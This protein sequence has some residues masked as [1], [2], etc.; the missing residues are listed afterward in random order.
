MNL[1]GNRAIT[2]D[3]K[4]HAFDSGA[5]GLLMSA[6]PS[7]TGSGVFRHERSPSKGGRENLVATWIQVY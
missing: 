1:I 4:L 2:I 5:G 6:A 3:H 7:E